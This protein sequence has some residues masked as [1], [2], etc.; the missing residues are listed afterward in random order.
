MFPFIILLLMFVYTN[1]A[2]FEA[3]SRANKAAFSIADYVSR[4]TDPIDTNF[5]TGL[6]D[7]FKFLNNEGDIGLRVSAVTWA[8]QG[9]GSHAYVLD[10][11][12]ATG[13]LSAHPAST[14]LESR[15]PLLAPGEQVLVVETSR[16]WQPLFDVGLGF[17]DFTDLVTIK[18]RFATQ[19]VFEGA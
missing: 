17:M 16:Q 12:S 9:D 15:V 6:G 2:A 3:K 10:W 19:V 14:N 8:S 11:S 1:F 5:V 18:P 4:Q 7:I 13:S